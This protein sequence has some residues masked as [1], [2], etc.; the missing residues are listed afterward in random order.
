MFG[1]RLLATAALIGLTAV[2][3]LAQTTAPVSPSRPA[4]TAPLAPSAPVAAPAPAVARPVTAA[5]SV[6][7]PAVKKANLNTATAEELDALPDVGKARTKAIMDERAKGKFK[8]WADFDKRMADTSVN[9][10]VKTKI[11]NMVTF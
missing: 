9:A 1:K 3:V 7:T 10:G 6:T 11:E 8:D 5:P 4:V 2:P